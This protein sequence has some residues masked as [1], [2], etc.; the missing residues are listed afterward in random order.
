MR[1]IGDVHGKL[2]EY[3]EIISKCRSSIQVGDFGFQSAHAWHLDVVGDEHNICFGNHDYMPYVYM[4][5]SC[6][7]WEVRDGGKIMIIRGALSID[8]FMREQGVDWFPNEEMSYKE[9]ES[10]VATYEMFKPEIVISHTCPR[11]IKHKLFG[12][13]DKPCITEQGL[14]V[15][16]NSHQP[17]KWIFGHFH[18]SIQQEVNGTLFQCLNELEYVDI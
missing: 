4:P 10:C 1:I 3:F 18:E 8:A 9:M 12:L 16:F 2:P 11:N 7:D 14:Q 6:S 13:Y 17:K 15:M 5:H